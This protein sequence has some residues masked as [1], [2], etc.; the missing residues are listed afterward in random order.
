MSCLALYEFLLI[1]G[2]TIVLPAYVYYQAWVLSGYDSGILAIIIG[3]EL[4]S[5]VSFGVAIWVL[6]QVNGHLRDKVRDMINVIWTR[7]ST[8]PSNNPG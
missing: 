1:F 8:T 2:A 5:V 7:V 3:L 6:Q 4:Y